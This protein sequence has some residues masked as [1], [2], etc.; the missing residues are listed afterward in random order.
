[1]CYRHYQCAVTMHCQCV[2]GD[3]FLAWLKENLLDHNTYPPRKT[4]LVVDRFKTQRIVSRKFSL[5]VADLKCVVCLFLPVALPLFKLWM[6]Q[7]TGSSSTRIARTF[8][9]GVDCRASFA[10]QQ[11]EKDYS[12]R[13]S[14]TTCWRH[15]L[16]FVLKTL[17]LKLFFWISQLSQI[18]FLDKSALCVVFSISTL[19]KKPDFGSKMSDN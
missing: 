9:R 12:F 10:N 19:P 2:S 7:S 14:C 13:S 18:R 8:Q 11:T 6:C 5:S 16:C 4:L 1:M 17:T 15:L 3:S